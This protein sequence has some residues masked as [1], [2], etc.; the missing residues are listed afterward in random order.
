[1]DTKVLVAHASKYGA[2]MEIAKKIA[3]VLQQEGFRAELAPVKSAGDMAQYQAVVLGIAVYIGNWRKEGIAF[4]KDH[5]QLLAERPLWIF[6]SG[7]TGRESSE[8]FMKGERFP[9]SQQPLMDR[10]RPRD[11]VVFP[12]AIDM[13]KLNFL[14]RLVIKNVK[15][16]TGDF[17]DW[18][19]IT[20][21][22]TGI[23]GE[24]KKQAG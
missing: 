16:A 7:P 8:A 6:S 4:L 1:M 12:G 10:I 18:N 21:W 9:K 5:E 3:Q 11:A 2:T 24:L 14:D 17:R 15:A 23:A 20:T 19:A 22:A 13:D